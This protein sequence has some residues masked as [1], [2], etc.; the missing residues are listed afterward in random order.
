MFASAIVGLSISLGGVKSNLYRMAEDNFQ[1]IKELSISNL[2]TAAGMLVGALSTKSALGAV[3][4]SAIFGLLSIVK[5]KK[6]TLLNIINFNKINNTLNSLR[7][8]KGVYVNYLMISVLGWLGGYGINIASALLVDP[9]VVGT[10]TFMYTITSVL[11]MVA[12]IVNNI[13]LAKFINLKK[14]KSTSYDDLNRQ[15]FFCEIFVAFVVGVLSLVL[16]KYLSDKLDFKVIIEVANKPIEFSLLIA[17]III[18]IPTWQMQNYYTVESLA[19]EYRSV[20]VIS[21]VIA[22]IAWITLMR[23][24]GELGLYAGALVSASIKTKMLERDFYKR[25]QFHSLFKT[26]LSMS[27]VL[28]VISLIYSK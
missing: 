5:N 1:A 6:I 12:T 3:Y 18:S 16:F 27:I 11:T 26:A 2:V 25:W 17:A 23:V 9:S 14:R 4:C 8:I 15:V 7:Q 28:I 22:L 24:N 21:A 10:Y 13:W 20:M 19:A